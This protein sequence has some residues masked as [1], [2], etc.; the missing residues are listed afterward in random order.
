[1]SPEDTRNHRPA[2][3]T[4]R[5]AVEAVQHASRLS[6]RL[7]YEVIRRD[8]QEE[9]DRP[10]N[11]LIWSGLAAGV[12][13]SFSVL[14]EAYLRTYLPDADWRPLVENFGYS[15]GFLLVI[16]GRM[17]LFTENTITT[18]MPLSIQRFHEG[19]RRILALWS[20]V[21]A[22][23]IVGALAAAVF[24]A[25]SGAIGEGA[26]RAI[27]D[28]SLHVAG[29]SAWETFLR[30]IPAG[31][32]IA[33]IVWMLPSAG[34]NA[35]WIILV[36]TYLIALGDFTHVIAGAVEV[37]YLLVTGLLSIEQTLLGFLVPVFF[38][39]VIGGTAVFTLLAW[40]QVMREVP[41]SGA[42]VVDPKSDD[43][44]D[45]GEGHRHSGDSP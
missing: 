19:F 27:E 30:G 9:L 37:L 42:V 29:Y 10:L 40:G 43:A 28:I 45:D 33:A 12:L 23:N 14:G 32:L 22:A 20:T 4:E 44:Q 18:V 17:Q 1:M 24:I 26:L 5:E 36:F 38:G 39:N 34:G 11:S 31:I 41:E 7:I 21:L 35:F 25:Y 6:P 8:G 16:L 15:F 2:P 13:I 3:T